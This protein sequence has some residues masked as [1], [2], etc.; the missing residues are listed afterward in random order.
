MT[1]RRKASG[2]RIV[3]GERQINEMMHE[4]YSKQDREGGT[5]RC[6][7]VFI[8][9]LLNSYDK[10]MANIL[11]E[12]STNIHYLFIIKNSIWQTACHYSD[13]LGESG[14]FE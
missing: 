11:T 5:K 8:A 7:D 6:R 13:V 4:E 9:T 14:T 1:D 12:L 10:L 3:S 2:G